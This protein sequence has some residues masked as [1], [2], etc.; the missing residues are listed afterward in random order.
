MTSLALA[1][2]FTL[3]AATAGPGTDLSALERPVLE[4][5]ARCEGLTREREEHAAAALVLADEIARQKALTGSARAGRALERSLQAFERLAG[6]L[7]ELDRQIE[8]ARSN[9][10][11]AFRSFETAADRATQDLVHGPL[12]AEEKAARL[13]GL[14]GI[15]R[16]LSESGHVS[17]GVRPPI[18][19][20]LEETDGPEEL[21]MKAAVVGAERE[22]LSRE[23]LRLEQEDRL[24]TARID[25]KL[26]LLRELEAAQR[27]AGPDLG[28]VALQADGIR[29]SLRELGQ[30][31][32]TQA[33]ESSRLAR[34]LGE[35]DARLREIENRR[36]R[37]I[38]RPISP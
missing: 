18:E 29:R 31:R 37:L 25:L 28:L 5:H 1:A 27:D 17:R 11:Q 9:L 33:E 24:L 26:Q 8:K 2:R 13:A 34:S 3:L 7:D 22:R 4:A 23:S 12:A 19:V 20:S 14:E 36:E 30:D 32:Q 6:K 38:P 35:L 15:R 21:A 16:R 10:R